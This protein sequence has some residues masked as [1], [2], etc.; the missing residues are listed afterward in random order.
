ERGARVTLVVGSVTAALPPDAE[1]VRVDTTAQMKDAVLDILATSDVLVMAAAV[2]DFRPARLATSKLTREE[3]L[4][5]DLEP[6]EDIL[7]AAP[8]P[9]RATPDPG[10]RPILVGFAAETGSLERAAEKLSRKGVD[11]LV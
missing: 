2:A 4:T 1:I 6:T 3:G 10:Q 5:I 9:A 7:A 11:L 8:A